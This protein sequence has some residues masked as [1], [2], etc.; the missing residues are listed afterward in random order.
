MKVVSCEIPNPVCP[1]LIHSGHQTLI[2]NF[3]VSERSEN[4]QG[5]S[6]EI[7]S[8]FHGTLPIKIH[9]AGI[10]S[11]HDYFDFINP[12]IIASDSFFNRQNIISDFINI[13]R[14][15]Y[16]IWTENTSVLPFKCAPIEINDSDSLVCFIDPKNQYVQQIVNEIEEI[17]ASSTFSTHNN[18][19]KSQIIVNHLIKIN[20]IYY[21]HEEI[22][23]EIGYQIIR[24]PDDILRDRCANCID[25]TLLLCSLLESFH[26]DPIIIG[27]K[28]NEQTWHIMPGFWLV[29]SPILQKSVI[30]DK[31]LVSSLIESFLPIDPDALL[32]GATFDDGRHL[33]V[34]RLRA[35][36]ELF[37]IDVKARRRS[38]LRPIQR[39]PRVSEAGDEPPKS[40]Y[41]NI[42]YSNGDYQS[43]IPD[44]IFEAFQSNRLTFIIGDVLAKSQRGSRKSLKA[45]IADQ[46]NLKNEFDLYDAFT[47]YTAER[48][49]E[50]IFDRMKQSSTDSIDRD[51]YHLLNLHGIT[52]IS[53][54]PDH[55]LEIAA[56]EVHTKRAL[57]IV[58]TDGS[59]SALSLKD[60]DSEI[61]FLHGLIQNLSNV[62]LTL[63]D[64]RKLQYKLE[65]NLR[66]LLQY[67]LSRG[68]VIFLKV[69]F[70]DYYVQWFFDSLLADRGMPSLFSVEEDVP[71]DRTEGIQTL[72]ITSKQLISAIYNYS[73]MHESS[74][75]NGNYRA[76]VRLPARPYKGL[77]AFQPEDAAIFFSREDDCRGIKEA[78]LAADTGIHIL[79]G[80]SGVGKTSV[81]KAGLIPALAKETKSKILYI[82]PGEN[83]SESLFYALSLDIEVLDHEVEK[84]D[85]EASL[86]RGIEGSFEEQTYDEIFLIIDQFEEANFSHSD[87]QLGTFL[88]SLANATL[89]MSARFRTLIVVRHEF[90]GW[91]SR[92]SRKIPNL[93]ANISYL[94][95]FDRSQA[96][97]AIRG[98]ARL[99]GIPV[100]EE[101]ILEILNDLGSTEILP[102]NLQLVLDCVYRESSL[103]GMKRRVYD[104]LGRCAGIIQN[105]LNRAL[106]QLDSETY[107]AARS[108]LAALVTSGR[109][110]R[111]LQRKEID[112][113]TSTQ[114]EDIENVLANLIDAR[115]L[116]TSKE[117]SFVRYELAHES[118]A[119][120]IGEWISEEDRAAKQAEEILRQ[121]IN[122]AKLNSSHIMPP[123][124]LKLIGE[125]ERAISLD[126]PGLALL[127]KS[128]QQYGTV[129]PGLLAKFDRLDIPQKAELL[130]GVNLSNPHERD[131]S[132]LIFCQEEFLFVARPIH[133]EDYLAH[134][135]ISQLR[136]E[137]ES[138]I[139]RLFALAEVD[140]SG[141][142]LTSLFDEKR[143][144]NKR[145]KNLRS[146]CFEI[147]QQGKYGRDVH[148]KLLENFLR[149]GSIPK[150]VDESYLANLSSDFWNTFFFRDDFTVQ[151]HE[152]VSLLDVRWTFVSR[153]PSWHWDW[154]L[155]KSVIR[156][157]SKVTQ[158][159]QRLMRLFAKDTSG[160]LQRI[161]IRWERMRGRGS[162]RIRNAVLRDIKNSNRNQDWVAKALRDIYPNGR[163]GSSLLETFIRLRSDRQREV[164]FGRRVTCHPEL[165]GPR[166][167]KLKKDR[168]LHLKSWIFTKETAQYVSRT[169]FKADQSAYEVRLLLI[170]KDYSGQTAAQFR[171]LLENSN[172]CQVDRVLQM[173]QCLPP[174]QTACFLRCFH[175]CEPPSHKL[176]QR[177]VEH[178]V[179]QWSS[180]LFAMAGMYPDKEL[181]AR[182]RQSLQK[183]RVAG[184]YHAVSLPTIRQATVSSIAKDFVFV[185]DFERTDIG[186]VPRS[187]SVDT[188]STGRSSHNPQR[189][190]QSDL[191]AW[192]HRYTHYPDEMICGCQY[193]LARDYDD[194]DK[195]VNLREPNWRENIEN[196]I[197]YPMPIHESL[198]DELLTDIDYLM[199]ILQ[200]S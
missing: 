48:N 10:R 196:I 157:S 42:A 128:H 193:S 75:E 104:E 33:A 141:C 116:S 140:S 199:N 197:R 32:G 14:H 172:K 146:R 98:P 54:F 50:E 119:D 13:Y 41:P 95:L 136:T 100:D 192:A 134:Q 35:C 67:R 107:L 43:G 168:I 80:L 144:R 190:Q 158:H 130:L 173:T 181:D 17:H 76:Q 56:R 52:V 114:P 97:Q 187:T 64:Q 49:K 145:L 101:L 99:L 153:L 4:P 111:R 30:R 7:P 1:L 47:K 102:A 152:M 28:S 118:L 72:E 123:E 170:G 108:V 112:A 120:R 185:W 85:F 191:Y 25:L 11:N 186:F 198:P 138:D 179:P 60:D 93:M 132:I 51:Y 2:R 21:R 124:K 109:T 37:L 183:F 160:K 71:F 156:S 96:L 5:Y 92:F 86:L 89:R 174:A 162:R 12:P 194:Y 115:I 3:A 125:N 103:V 164:L 79:C 184:H 163:L 154:R 19:R 40:Y 82:R 139:Q 59:K 70:N 34:S 169:I 62:V 66:N 23:G 133:I 117:G 176:A 142:I 188:V 159:S 182:I 127:L 178:A 6:V 26:I 137:N 77:E 131:V 8:L 180:L 175:R 78:F 161:C 126:G 90:L 121:E 83:L 148:A 57:Q 58:T 45:W 113:G 84:L 143:L 74:S 38:G 63:N 81:I 110:R 44:E 73:R 61:Y 200:I 155:A 16:K 65:N 189:T 147:A 135:I 18:I 150:T 27:I 167:A 105:H 55:M 15:G 36:E 39:I 31:H 171:K 195:N 29:R 87:N 22:L 129:P 24:F 149:K 69:N 46:L 122:I 166:L 177:I 106:S 91:L 165:L 151:E 94:E 53:L 68:A 88:R 20:S 9:S